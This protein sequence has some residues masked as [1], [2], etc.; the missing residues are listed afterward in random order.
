MCTKAHASGNAVSIFDH[1]GWNAGIGKWSENLSL[2][3]IGQR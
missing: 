3:E 2:T 1:L